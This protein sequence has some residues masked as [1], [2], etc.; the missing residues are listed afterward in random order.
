M[1]RVNSINPNWMYFGSPVI[2]YLEARGS[3]IGF[4]G[5]NLVEF[6][7]KFSLARKVRKILGLTFFIERRIL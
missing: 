3:M 1:L 5:I 7:S 4:G 6:I 2:C